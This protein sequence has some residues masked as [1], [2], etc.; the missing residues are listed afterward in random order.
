MT[1]IAGRQAPA[2]SRAGSAHR[3][4]V[5]QTADGLRELRSVWGNIFEQ[6]RGL[7]I[8]CTWEWMASWWAHFGHGRDLWLLLVRAP[9]GSLAGIAPLY[10]RVGR[11]GGLL[12][13]RRIQLLGA[14]STDS[15]YLDFVSRAGSEAAVARCVLDWLFS[16]GSDWDVLSLHT[17]PETSAVADDMLRAALP[18]RCGFRADR[19]VCSSVHLGGSWEAYLDT[20]S[21]GFGASVRYALRRLEA[22]HRVAVALARTPAELPAGLRSLF[23]VHT[24][25]WALARERGAFRSGQRRGFYQ[26]MAAAFLGRG[27]LRFYTLRVDDAVVAHQFCF[28]LDRRTYVLQ[29]AYDPA[30]AQRSV[31]HALRAYV[32]QDC[33]RRGVLEYDFLGGTT[34]HKQAWGARPKYCV[35]L[36][37]W[38][39][40]RG[41]GALAAAAWLEKGREAVKRRLPAAALDAA[42][43]LRRLVRRPAGTDGAP[44]AGD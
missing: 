17:V 20:L 15:D 26:D 12:A 44:G 42:R 33:I 41:R 23:D 1:A 6:S 14:G 21:P 29:E 30:W 5:I 31:G 40:P 43:S 24:R 10:R 16:K 36:D 7:S 27:W 25:R 34:P 28:E 2:P 13:V 35:N 8:F 32:L 9:D 22:A 38:S 4:E 39:G 37:L 18:P 19:Q 11:A 3:V